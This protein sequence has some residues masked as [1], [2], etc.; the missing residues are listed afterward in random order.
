MSQTYKQA[1]EEPDFTVICI[2]PGNNDLAQHAIKS[3]HLFS[4]KDVIIHRGARKV[5]V[6]VLKI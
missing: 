2:D 1:K 4:M 5:D 6:P 3:T